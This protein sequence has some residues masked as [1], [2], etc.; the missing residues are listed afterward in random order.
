MPCGRKGGAPAASRNTRGAKVS[1]PAAGAGEWTRC[2][3]NA[4]GIAWLASGGRGSRRDLG[5]GGTPRQSFRDTSDM[6][7]SLGLAARRDLHHQRGL[8]QVG[9]VGDRSRCGWAGARY[10][11]RVAGETA[12]PAHGWR[13]ISVFAELRPAS[14]SARPS[15]LVRSVDG[16]RADSGHLSLLRAAHRPRPH[17]SG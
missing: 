15:Q 1:R 8:D 5:S 12:A 13:D 6:A 10:L 17:S 2:T 16:P 14:D 7:S 11:R 3:N 4:R 9:L